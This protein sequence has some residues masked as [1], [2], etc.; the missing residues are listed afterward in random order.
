MSEP[1][2]YA[3]LQVIPVLAGLQGSLQ[4]QIGDQLVPAARRAG[5][6]AGRAVADGM[7]S[8]ESAIRAA[9]Q[10]LAAARDAERDAAGNLR[11]A[12]AHLDDVR[13]KSSRTA[14]ELAEAEERV[15][16]AQRDSDRAAAGR[17]SAVDELTRARAR[18]NNEADEGE[19]STSRW[20][21]ALRDFGGSADAAG[22]KLA[23]LATAAAGIGGAF[24]VGMQA[25][26]NAQIENKLAAQLG[27]TGPLAQ[28][29][30][31][32][33]AR[34][35]RAGLGDSMEDSAEAIS[36]VA[37][38][39]RTAGFEG[40]KSMEAIGADAMNFAKIFDTDITEAVHTASQLVTNG[41]AK[42]ST[43]AFDLMTA[44]FQRVPAAMRDELPE[45]LNEYGTHFRGLGFDGEQAFNLL[46]DAAD[47][48]KWA[49]DKTG[50]SL[51]EFSIRGSDM[52]KASTEAYEALGLDAEEMSRKVA[53][54]GAEAQDALQ[55][56]SYALLE[57]E[58]P[59]ERANTAIALFGTPLEDLAVDQIPEFFSA[60]AEG[61]NSMSGFEGSM[62]E[63]AET[64]NSG[65]GVA[66]ESLK[67]SIMGGLTDAF[68]TLA[69]FVMQN[70]DAL[71]SLAIAVTPLVGTIVAIKGAMMAWSA[72]QVALNLAMNANPIMLLVTAV[73]ALVAGVIYAYRES[74]TF[75]SI[76]QSAWD[77]I[78]S[79]AMGAWEGFIKPAFDGIVAGGK[80][81]GDAAMWLWNSAIMPAWNGISGVVST[82]WNGFV[83]PMLENFRIAL[84]LLGDA[85]TWLWNNAI[86]P[87]WN[88]ISS[89]I[90]TVWNATVGPIID[91]AQT[92]FRAVG[93]V[94][95]WLYN[96]AI[97][98]AWN[99]IQTAIS[100]VW[101]FL[102]PI[103]TKIGDGMNAIG[104]IASSV[105]SGIK[106]AF[107]GVVDVLKAPVRY[108]GSLLQKI[109]AKVG[110]FTVPGAASLNSWGA[111][112]Q[113]LR[114]GG[115]VA[116]RRSDGM[117]Y[118]PGTGT[119][120]SILGVGPDG[121][122]TALVSKGEFVVNAEATAANL[123]LLR[124]L[125]AGWVP[126]AE[127]VRA[128]VQDGDFRGDVAPRGI[129]DDNE[130]IG[131]F[132]DARR[133]VLDSAEWLRALVVDGDFKA[134]GAPAGVSDDNEALGAFLDARRDT[135]AGAEWLRALV[136]DGDFK[137]AGAPRGVSDDNELVGA[138]LD[139]RSSL[140][141]R[142]PRFA[143]GGLVSADELVDFAKGVEGQPYV[144]G[145]VNWGDCSGAV[146]ALANFATGRDPFASRFA[147]GTEGEELKKRGFLPGLGPAGSLNIGYYN[148]G[149]W[150]G[151][152]SATLPNG[153]NFEMGGARGDGQYGGMAA[154]ADDPMYTDHWHLPPEY[155]AGG[156]LGS[157]TFGGSLSDGVSF[158]GSGS[159]ASG[160]SGGSTFAGGSSSSSGSSSGGS[161]SGTPVFVTNWPSSVGALAGAAAAPAAPATGT[162]LATTA[163]GTEE[164]GAAEPSA[165]SASEPGPLS[166]ML[167]NLQAKAEAFAGK[168]EQ[169]G[170]FATKAG[171][172]V[173]MGTA[174]ANGGPIDP[175]ALV[176][177]VSELATL[178]GSILE[179][180]QQLGGEG[181]GASYGEGETG[182]PEVDKWGEWAKNAAGQWESFFKDHW[183]EMLNTAVGVGL[184]ARGSGG[185]TYNISGPNPNAVSRVIARNQRRRSLAAQR[186]GG[187]GR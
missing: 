136:Q 138:F 18:A 17:A 13:N 66:L 119:S 177:N 187:F 100:A 114:S 144:W 73:G 43:E 139:A 155:F 180:P 156:D 178:G 127:F 181:V 170:T 74:E 11:I 185:D 158:G 31:E 83:S 145:G 102:S 96:E 47:R 134:T 122:P 21:N 108:V 143:D 118:G 142:L 106:S 86:V 98:P 10:R 23:G 152:T 68:G 157:P 53:I 147:T 93:D 51:K 28:E 79:A 78:K 70:S 40:E 94:A 116:G 32:N 124:A 46:V 151:H 149:P 97:Q 109:P 128:L 36:A 59:A 61:S 39:F 63:A 38:S 42:D 160:G 85:A 57:M 120:D 75:R 90:S 5:Q 173:A 58:D 87:A 88:G 123:P 52:S 67:R 125:N 171:E 110:P 162:G 117:L 172:L 166:Q 121:M 169:I 111:S 89:V 30:G 41:I 15:A 101:D 137:A 34:L 20:S 141:S 107:S 37:N 1:I 104:S 163:T 95:M 113:A 183:K 167:G 45:I 165:A 44:S 65:P 184:G 133:G 62:A 76:V 55:M 16:R 112:L 60:I 6:D 130:A 48:G 99:G 25:I 35:Y 153:V 105:A 161:G 2:G 8:S 176:G 49:L 3:S 19:R 7:Q 56:V 71:K 69:N 50:D 150:G 159:G 154:G 82:V 9:S 29:Y 115:Q 27:A 24:A 14:A 131:A 54:G 132:L 4:S 84:G 146:S 175:A 22:G 33:A 64:M 77:G 103:F 80:A 164:S 81:V 26:E 72:A 186:T 140:L 126:S 91:G 179:Q 174:A 182:N 168:A 135:L 148:G 12:E 129:S 92:A